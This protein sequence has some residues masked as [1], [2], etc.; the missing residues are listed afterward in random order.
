MLCKYYAL[1]WRNFVAKN[2]I[3]YEKATNKL[4]AKL[5]EDVQKELLKHEEDGT[6]DSEGYQKAMQVFYDRHMCVVRPM[7]E[8]L[9]KSMMA[10]KED[11]TVHLTM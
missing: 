9:I 10:L 2:F 11:N 6:T 8:P 4:R 3:V 5:P 7:P 1:L